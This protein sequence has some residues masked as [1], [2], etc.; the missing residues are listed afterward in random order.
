[1]VN[2]YGAVTDRAGR[3]VACNPGK[4][5]GN[6]TMTSE[7]LRNLPQSLKAD[8]DAAGSPDAGATSSR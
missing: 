2:A 7:L 6:L 8:W 5:W 4:S 1:M 3:L